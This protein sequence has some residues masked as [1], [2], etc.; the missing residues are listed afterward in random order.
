MAGAI[1]VV[2]LDELHT[3]WT[4]ASLTALLHSRREHGGHFQLSALGAPFPVLD[5][6]IAGDVAAVHY[7]PCAKTAG[8]QALGTIADAGDAEFPET[9]R[10]ERIRLPGSVLLEVEA[11]LRCAAEFAETNDRPT[12]VDWVGL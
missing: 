5:I 2:A 10:G 4:T 9:A 8:Y 12:V 7:F 3:V 11:A 1:E 6:L